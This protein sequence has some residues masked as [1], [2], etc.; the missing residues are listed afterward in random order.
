MIEMFLFSGNSFSVYM[1]V[2][3]NPNIVLFFSNISMHM[4][5]RLG[6]SK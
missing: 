3:Y 2:N 6:A 5:M 4:L 1:A